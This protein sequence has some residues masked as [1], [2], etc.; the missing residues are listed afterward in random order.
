MRPLALG[1]KNYLFCG[2]HEA[3]EHTAVI[4]SLL[5]TCKLNN[6]NPT[7]WLTDV[8][9]HINEHKANELADLLPKI[10]VEKIL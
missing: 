3:A 4:Y 1:R 9:N 5:E 10:W 2:S 8:L 6:V 7:E